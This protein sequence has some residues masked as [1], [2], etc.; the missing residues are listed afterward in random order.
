MRFIDRLKLGLR[1]LGPVNR[2]LFWGFV[3]SMFLNVA[4]LGI[5]YIQY[6]D[7]ATKQDISESE[8]EAA[9]LERWKQIPIT[10]LTIGFSLAPDLIQY[11]RDNGYPSAINISITMDQQ[12]P[13]STPQVD[14]SDVHLDWND[15]VQVKISI[16]ENNPMFPKTVGELIGHELIV[17]DND[18]KPW[19][20]V[21]SIHF[22]HRYRAVTAFL[23]LRE[24]WHEYAGAYYFRVWYP[25]RPVIIPGDGS[26]RGHSGFV[27]TPELFEGDFG[28]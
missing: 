28:Y 15:E 13:I 18:V 23:V 5:A 20:I 22:Y 12:Q 16:Q 4:S 2:V 21:K 25:S 11:N 19:T 27:I 7:S 9:R 17:R 6:K 8:A 1:K 3:I 10:D 24:N 26:F 14:V